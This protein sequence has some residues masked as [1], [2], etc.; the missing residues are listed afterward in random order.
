[1]TSHSPMIVIDFSKKE[2]NI[3]MINTSE[4]NNAPPLELTLLNDLLPRMN[5][6][7]A[8]KKRWSN[9]QKGHCGESHLY[10]LLRK[11]LPPQYL[12]LSDLL[13]EHQHTKFQIDLLLISKNDVF[14]LEVKNYKGNY[15][16][17]NDNWYTTSSQVEISNPLHQL[18]RSEL[19]LR[20]LLEKT[21]FRF[22]IKPYLV[23]VNP[24]F[25]LYQAPLDAPIIFRTQL[26]QFINQLQATSFEQTPLQRKL[27]NYLTSKQLSQSP[28]GRL[29]DYDFA[30]L[31][32]GI[33]CG[34]CSAFVEVYN[35]IKVIC[36][37]CQKQE[38]INAAVN[39]SVIEFNLLFPD[40]KITVPT[41]YKWCSIIQSQKTIRRILKKYYHQV[42]V[43]NWTH[44]VFKE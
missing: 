35:R 33:V 22:S 24:T 25:Q 36:R 23:F 37:S 27:A 17:Q 14:L 41:I 5:A 38:S 31:R 30:S 32:K 19:L 40:E 9:V 8:Q 12:L 13:L 3:H 39:R 28:R 34:E 2:R 16:I 7:T 21:S 20:Q 42:G 1:M 43:N 18:K 11:E 15:V 4:R 10:Q 44:Y 29:P 6:S 26:N